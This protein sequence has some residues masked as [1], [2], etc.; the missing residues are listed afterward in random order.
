MPMGVGYKKY[1]SA[2]MPKKVGGKK[3][4]AGKKPAIQVTPR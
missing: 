2:G 3:K 1:D 4:K